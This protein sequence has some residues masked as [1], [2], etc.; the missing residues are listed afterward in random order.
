MKKRIKKGQ[1]N[2]N[3]HA[4]IISKDMAAIA[5]D[6]HTLL[7]ATAGIAEET[8]V[9]ARRRLLA[10]LEN[11]KAAYSHLQEKA[12][13]SAK[14]AD[15]AVHDYP[16]HAIGIAFGLGALIGFLVTGCKNSDK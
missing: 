8:V 10:A 7:T 14:V 11:G 13:E 5:E 1:N 9:D 2:M 15:K 6:A 4:K 16:Y 12:V 3:K